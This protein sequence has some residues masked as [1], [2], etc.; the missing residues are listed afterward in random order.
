MSVFKPITARRLYEMLHEATKNQ[1]KPNAIDMDAPIEVFVQQDCQDAM[2][3]GEFRCVRSIG[4]DPDKPGLI[5]SVFD[6]YGD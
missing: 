6:T 1:G 2:D 5:I 4:G 3:D